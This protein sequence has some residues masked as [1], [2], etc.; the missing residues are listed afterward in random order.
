M[1]AGLLRALDARADVD[2]RD[3]QYRDQQAA[4]LKRN[5]SWSWEGIA[6]CPHAHEFMRLLCTRR[7][8]HQGQCSI[9]VLV[10]GTLP[11]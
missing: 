3:Q 4:V 2:D 9:D 7:A 5:G 11:W 1:R 10:E 6:M 8:G